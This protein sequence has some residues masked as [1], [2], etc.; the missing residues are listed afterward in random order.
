MY[1]ECNS[2]F[3]KILEIVQFLDPNHS[4]EMVVQIQLR[5]IQLWSGLD[6]HIVRISLEMVV[7]CYSRFFLLFCS[8]KILSVLLGKIID[9][10]AMRVLIS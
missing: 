9:M 4:C 5:W 6:I 8:N 2:V 1:I 10:F 3:L 7:V